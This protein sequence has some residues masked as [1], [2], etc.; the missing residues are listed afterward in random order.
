MDSF[1]LIC[2]SRGWYQAGIA[3]LEEAMAVASAL[4]DEERAS[5]VRGKALAS[6]G[7]FATVVGQLEP[8]LSMGQEA[9]ALLR[10]LDQPEA[11]MLALYCVCLSYLYVEDYEQTL[12]TVRGIRQIGQTVGEQWV[13]SESLTYAASALLSQG[14]LVEAQQICDEVLNNHSLGPLNYMGL[15]WA[16]LMRGQASLIQ[17]NYAEAQPFFERGLK[18]AQ[19]LNYRRPLQQCYDNLG[20][21][22]FYLA[23]FN[24]AEHYFLRSLEISEEIDQAREMV[25]AVYDLARVWAAQG[26]KSEALELVALILQHPLRNLTPILRIERPTFSE[27]AE[28]LRAR[29]EADLAPDVYQAAWQRGQT[30]TLE[31]VVAGL[32]R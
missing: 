2:E 12:V 21:T 29:L 25:G 30:L 32:L 4:A 8:G 27:A 23:E 5:L 9:I 14:K 3:M 24:Q 19:R 15:V 31:T 13:S 26:K 16:A 7:F 18:A 28:R 20:D 10:P 1:W 17:G 22:A 6:M 11:L